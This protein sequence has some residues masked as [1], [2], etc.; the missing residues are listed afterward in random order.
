MI[1]TSMDAMKVLLFYRNWV[2]RIIG[3]ALAATLLQGCTAIKLGYNTAPTVSYWWLDGYF[4]FND[5]Q[6]VRLREDLGALQH[7]HR[8]QQLPGYARLLQRAQ[9]LVAQPKVTAAQVCEIVDDAR[10]QLEDIAT[11][12]EPGAVALVTSLT[13]ANLS[14]LQA[15]YEDRNAEFRKEWLDASPEKVRKQRYDKAL[16]RIETLYGRLDASQRAVV[17]QQV[18]VSSYDAR[19]LHTERLRRQQDT[20]ETLGKLAGRP[21]QDEQAT[22]AVRGLLERYRVSPVASYRSY[23]QRQI[24]EGCAGF[25]LAHN[26]TTPEQR[27]KAVNRLK[28][29]ERDVKE[30]V[31]QD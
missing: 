9:T 31:A 29:Y 28:S 27:D 16:D 3:L 2:G 20:L 30:L 6:A 26:S 23:A 17:R 4:D 7:W 24:D 19:I 22:R 21:A 10:R 1:T 14:R 11:Q 5:A 15:K 12:A 8:G 13:P 18:A 25:A